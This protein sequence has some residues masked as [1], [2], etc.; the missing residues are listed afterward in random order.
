IF[1]PRATIEE[2]TDT[3]LFVNTMP[4]FQAARNAQS[5]PTLDWTSDNCSSSPDNPLGFKFQSS[6]Q[7]H[8]FGYRNYK[9]QNRFTEA[10]R[11]KIDDNFLKDLTDYCGGVSDLLEGVCNSLAKVYY[12]AV[13][14]FG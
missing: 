11:K 2:T 7:R 6:C 3:L 5:P 14:E 8:D 13:R 9:K 1:A 4:Q 12:E 10:N